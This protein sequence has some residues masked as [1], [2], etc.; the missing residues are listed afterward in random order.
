MPYN[1]SLIYKRKTGSGRTTYKQRERIIQRSLT[2]WL[3]TQYPDID[4]YNDWAA[5]AYLDQGQNSAK[6][7][8]DSLNGWVDLF[9]AEPSRGYHGLFIELKRDDVRPFLKDG[10][11]LCADK[12]IQKEGEFLVKQNKKGYYARFACGLDQA[13]KLI[14][15]YFEVPIEQE[16]F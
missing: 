15:W 6:L 4:F 10:K 16:L 12:Q 9:I 8:L 5:G 13:K 7:A 1:R 3:R 2:K 11:T 14:N